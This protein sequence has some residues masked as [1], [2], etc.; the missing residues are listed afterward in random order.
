MLHPPGDANGGQQAIAERY[1]GTGVLPVEGLEQRA[2]AHRQN[3]RRCFSSRV[4]RQPHRTAGRPSRS[5]LGP[6][7]H[8]WRRS[9]AGGDTSA[10]SARE[11]L[12][13]RRQRETRQPGSRGRWDLLI[14]SQPSPQLHRW[15]R[16]AR[17]RMAGQSG[18]FQVTTGNRPKGGAAL[19]GQANAPSSDPWP[20]GVHDSI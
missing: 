20:Q 15:S 3:R 2:A 6:S 11:E 14:P 10:V 18:A 19:G 7:E 5:T 16:S 17:R 8:D 12:V 13:N 4:Y 9:P 1:A